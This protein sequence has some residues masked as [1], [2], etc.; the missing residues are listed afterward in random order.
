MIRSNKEINIAKLLITGI[1]RQNDKLCEIDDS[2]FI[3][4]IKAGILYASTASNNKDEIRSQLLE[5]AIS[6]Y[7]KTWLKHAQEDDENIDEDIE[8]NNAR[9]TF[10]EY[11]NE[12]LK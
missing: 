10:L 4:I 1:F 8:I 2:I 9:Q 12:T 11:Y 6:E 7:I 3:P 5:H